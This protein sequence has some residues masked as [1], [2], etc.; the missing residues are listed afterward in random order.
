[1]S[2]FSKIC[3]FR[4]L[5]ELKS[6]ETIQKN[7]LF[8]FVRF[9]S[10][11]ELFK[12]LS[13]LTFHFIGA[14]KQHNFS[15]YQ[16]KCEYRPELKQCFDVTAIVEPLWDLLRCS[17]E[18]LRMCV[19]MS[20][21]WAFYWFR[22]FF[23]IHQATHRLIIFRVLV[24]ETVKQSQETHSLS[25]PWIFSLIRS[26]CI[27]ISTQEQAVWFSIHHQ[28]TQ[29]SFYPSFI[30][31]ETDHL[32]EFAQRSD[33]EFLFFSILWNMLFWTKAHLSLSW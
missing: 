2:I 31:S 13:A 4:E 1:M 24:L 28:K 7:I 21:E 22:V 25:P 16:L 10:F 19:W 32:R 27:D 14:T 33:S 9:C 3:S 12:F 15:I 29:F 20:E 26:W 11:R 17:I 5:Y 30:E 18:L 6:R 8:V 23:C